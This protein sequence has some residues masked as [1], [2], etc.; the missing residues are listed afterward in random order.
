MGIRSVLGLCA[1]AGIT[2]I[3]AERTGGGS[4][5]LFI[6]REDEGAIEADIL[7]RQEKAPQRSSRRERLISYLDNLRNTGALL[8][9]RG[10]L[11]N[12][13]AIAKA[14]EMDRNFL[15]EKECVTL[16]ESFDIEDRSRASIEKHD[17]LAAIK[18]YLAEIKRQ[19]ILLPRLPGGQSNKRAI[20]EASGFRRNIFYSDPTVAATLE[21]FA[22]N[23][24]DSL[25]GG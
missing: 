5:Q 13:V 6:R 18:R 17:D 24:R 8:S 12:K 19:G 22:R 9:R 1:A 7:A 21:D 14:A 4:K 25:S 10:R 20:A 11:P 2:M 15:C 23:E 16:L 3:A